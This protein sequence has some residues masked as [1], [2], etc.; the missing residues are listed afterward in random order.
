MLMECNEATYGRGYMEQSIVI[1]DPATGIK[2]RGKARARLESIH[3]VP[4]KVIEIAREAVVDARKGVNGIRIYRYGSKRIRVVLEDSD[5][6]LNT[7]SIKI[8]VVIDG[9]K[10]YSAKLRPEL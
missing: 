4:A 1:A 5:N 3:D 10:I 8:D 9:E 7:S 2:W 6:Y